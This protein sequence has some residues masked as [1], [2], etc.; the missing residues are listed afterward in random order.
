MR[1]TALATTFLL[2]LGLATALPAAPAQAGE[3]RFLVLCYPGGNVKTRDAEPS[4]KSMIELVEKLGGWPAGTFSS[5]FTSKVSECDAWMGEK[6]PFAIVSL[7]WW[8]AHAGDGLVPLVQP[9]IKGATDEVFRV[10]VRKGTYKSLDDLRGKTV[11]GTPLVEPD[12]LMK[13]VFG[14]RFKASDFVLEPS[15]QAL[16]ALR[17]LNDREV[18]AV[19]VTAQQFQSMGALP[20]AN[21]LEP[22]FTSQPIPLMGVVAN[23]KTTTPEERRRFQKALTSFCGHKDGRQFCELFGIDAFVPANASTYDAVKALWK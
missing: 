11:T 10:M 5:R 8:L 14:G 7:G 6:P 13:V 15:N 19:V 21:L 16:R 1:I 2:A 17:S 23:E 4:A 12:F 22:V 20:F 18:E 3:P 9:K